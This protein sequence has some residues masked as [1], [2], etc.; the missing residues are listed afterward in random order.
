MSSF[1]I[2]R[3]GFTSYTCVANYFI[4]KYMP[5][6]SGEFVK[7]Y[8]Y[9]L[10]CIEE[11]KSELSLSKIADAL[12]NTQKDV[13]RALKYWERQGLLRLSFDGDILIS[14]KLVS[15]SDVKSHDSGVVKKPEKIEVSVTPIDVRKKDYSRAEL[16]FYNDDEDLKQ[17]FYIIQKYLGRNLTSSDTNSI[18]Y[19][20]DTLKLPLDVIEYLFE[21]CVSKGKSNMRYIDKVAI[22]WAEKGV[23]SV[24]SAKM[25]GSAY[26][27]SSYAIM[28]A[29][30]INNRKP[31]DAE[32]KY[33]EKWKK[34][35]FDMDLIVEACN[36]TITAIHQP[37]F[38]YA[39]AILE[40]WKAADIKT[41]ED[42]RVLD[43]QYAG[44]KQ[45]VLSQQQAGT[46]AGKYNNYDQHGTS[47]KD[48]ERVLFN[49]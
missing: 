49:K 39:D 3:D 10:K 46:T 36:R 25:L 20:Y 38:E 30:G 12:E 8:I 44:K 19:Y 27:E 15:I 42:V 37:S 5:K 43:K 13:I 17:L 6:A 22:S 48:L 11:D 24:K 47:Y 4:E 7:I 16:S 31:G 28:K 26:S 21:Y 34:D 1:T 32:L 45:K 40:K 18:L 2:Q 33:I 41:K 14:L 29:F 35:G 23:A 9:L